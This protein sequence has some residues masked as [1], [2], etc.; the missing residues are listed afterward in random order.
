MRSAR[1]ARACGRNERR[2]VGQR[3]ALHDDDA[4]LD[5]PLQRPLILIRVVRGSCCCCRHG[6]YSLLS[7]N[8]FREAILSYPVLSTIIHWW[9]SLAKYFVG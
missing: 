3:A 2:A 5:C 7:P 4:C 8:C 1:S 6:H 9:H